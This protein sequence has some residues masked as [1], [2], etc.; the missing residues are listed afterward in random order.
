MN[1]NAWKNMKSVHSARLYTR[2]QAMEI[3]TPI[4]CEVC[5]RLFNLTD[6]EREKD[7]LA[8]EEIDKSI[9][10]WEVNMNYEAN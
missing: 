3:I 7:R 9:F 6:E 8:L 1:F 2:E 5:R 4:I 10:E